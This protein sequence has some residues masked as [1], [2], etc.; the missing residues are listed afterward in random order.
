MILVAHVVIALTSMV[1]SALLFLSPSRRKFHINFGLIG[2]T[3][4]SGTYLVIS[5]HSAML[6]ACMSGIA[7]LTIVTAGSLFA[8]RRLARET[9]RDER[10][11]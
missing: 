10:R 2:L 9:V 3:L 4:A 11:R 1:Y 6:S 5:T 8:Y 7:Y